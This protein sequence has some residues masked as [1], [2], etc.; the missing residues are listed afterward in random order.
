[1]RAF[2]SSHP[3]SADLAPSEKPRVIVVLKGHASGISDQTNYRGEY[4]LTVVPQDGGS[5]TTLFLPAKL[6]DS[7]A[8]AG[9]SIEDGAC[10][11]FVI[12]KDSWGPYFSTVVEN[13]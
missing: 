2:N 8:S 1:M 13:V 4:I 10:F 9:T 3:L 12:D 6:V 11:D 7:I 5:I